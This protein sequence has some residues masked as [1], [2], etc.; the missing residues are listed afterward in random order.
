MPSLSQAYAAAPTVQA[1]FERLDQHGA[2]VVRAVISSAL[3]LLDTKERLV[4]RMRYGLDDGQPRTLEEIG[5]YFKAS[6]W[7]GQHS[8]PVVKHCMSLMALAPVIEISR[9]HAV[10]TSW[11]RAG[12][13]KS[14][15]GTPCTADARSECYCGH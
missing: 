11:L 5:R 6:P 10:G 9:L 2:S 14:H 13:S 3:S 1:D 4:M 8:S 15:P 7:Q 12:M